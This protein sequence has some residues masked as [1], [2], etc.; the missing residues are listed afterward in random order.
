M[1]NDINNKQTIKTNKDIFQ[2]L[3]DNKSTIVIS[4]YPINL[5]EY[6]KMLTNLKINSF[7]IDISFI[8]PDRNFINLL[9]SA[10]NGKANLNSMTTFNFEKILQ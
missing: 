8:K 9:I 5:F 6:K 4:K 7:A 3:K 2:I 1:Q 10:F